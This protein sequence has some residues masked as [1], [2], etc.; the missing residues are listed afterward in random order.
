MDKW[1]YTDA[2]LQILVKSVHYR[3]L[4]IMGSR[5]D[6]SFPWDIAIYFSQLEEKAG[7]S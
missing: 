4:Y 7:E 1:D 2:L 5:Q 6:Q 3:H